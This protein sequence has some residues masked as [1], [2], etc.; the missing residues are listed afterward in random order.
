MTVSLLRPEL[1]DLSM[2]GAHCDHVPVTSLMRDVTLKSGR[3]RARIPGGGKG[4]TPLGALLGA[5]AEM[6][7]RLLAIIHWEVLSKHVEY[8]SYDELVR[9]GCHPLAPQHVPLFAPEQYANPS[10]EYAPFRPDTFL[11]WVE[12][13]ELL[14][15]CRYGPGKSVLMYY[16]PHQD[17]SAI[18]YSTT[19]GLAFHTSRREA[20]LHGL[21][22]VIERDALNVRWYA[23][24]P[25]PAR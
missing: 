6:S 18:S 9:R 22:E 16:R 10:F 14:T 20:I 1:L 2:Y 21:Y 19:A 7:E 24:L 23:K 5:W 17:E 15:G 12:A 8:G 25:P 13:R 3:S 4:A 11:G